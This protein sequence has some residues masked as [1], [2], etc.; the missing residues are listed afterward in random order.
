M[1][2]RVKIKRKEMP[3]TALNKGE[4]GII[5]KVGG[6]EQERRK[7]FALGLLPGEVIILE[8]GY[9]VILLGSG[10]TLTALDEEMAKNIFVKSLGVH[11]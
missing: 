7:L 3:V 6:S 5:V 2:G 11:Q 9:P 10:Y 4:G 1:K 8:E